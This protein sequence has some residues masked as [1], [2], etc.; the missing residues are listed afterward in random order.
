[1]DIVLAWLKGVGLFLGGMVA[2][3]LV[4]ALAATGILLV[5]GIIGMIVCAPIAAVM[6]S[7][8]PAWTIFGLV[9]SFICF[10]IGVIGL[11]EY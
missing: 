10:F 7:S 1:M 4:M 9:G 3:T 11:D 5:V 6:G 8:A 2:L